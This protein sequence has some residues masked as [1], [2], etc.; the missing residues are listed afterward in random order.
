MLGE[1]E[2]DLTV[3]GKAVVAARARSGARVLMVGPT[4][5]GT[6]SLPHRLARLPEAEGALVFCSGSTAVELA[7]PFGV[8]QGLV[9]PLRAERGLQAPTL[10][11]PLLDA[12]FE[13]AFSGN[14][15]AGPWPTTFADV[16]HQFH[17][18]L[19]TISTE[20]TVVLT[21]DD[22]CY[23]DDASLHALAHLSTRPTSQ[24]LLLAVVRET[25][26]S[27]HNPPVG[28]IASVATHQVRARPLSRRCLFRIVA[29]EL[30]RDCPQEFAQA[31]H[32]MS[33]GRPKDLRALCDGARLRRLGRPDRRTEA[34]RE[35]GVAVRRERLFLVLRREPGA[36]ALAKAAAVLGGKAADE[37]GEPLAG[38][39]RTQFHRARSV[40]T[41]AWPDDTADHT[42]VCVPR[43]AETVLRVMGDGGSCRRHR[44]AAGLL[45]RCGAGPEGVAAPL[46]QVDRPTGAREIQQLRVS[47]AAA[48]HRRAFTLEDQE[49]ADRVLG[50]PDLSAELRL[51]TL[52][53]A[54]PR[55][56]AE[57]RRNM[58]K[59]LARYLEC[60]QTLEPARRP[61]PAANCWLERAVI[62]QHRLGRCA[63]A[64][65]R[66]G[67]SCEPALAWGAP[68]AVYRSLAL[69]GLLT[70]GCPGIVVLR[71]AVDTFEGGVNRIE[72][73]RTLIGLGQWLRS[74][75][76]PAGN[77]TL[78]RG[79][80]LAAEPRTAQS[81]HGADT[82][83]RPDR[84]IA[85]GRSR[86]I[87]GRDELFSVLELDAGGP[88]PDR[89]RFTP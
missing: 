58:P 67:L 9:R 52:H 87:A 37:P 5:S 4:G 62:I 78:Q 12:V 80:R 28:E 85:A 60:G 88:V 53:R 68:T 64:E 89:H 72:L 40:L 25:L 86:G 24:H 14:R 49:L 59:A 11:A 44:E 46:L 26:L 74:A 50:G 76:D 6:A 63:E 16:L 34:S 17:I 13:E 32:E 70:E 3:L 23:A 27:A 22:L 56:R 19:A 31:G 7:F 41:T 18:L 30:G 66:A 51:T 10:T 65:R 84:A 69:R 33:G 47:V 36:S 77:R 42:G 79:R 15:S 21:L 71:D 2:H 48:R 38:L 55:L 20:R 75:A 57:T 29:D 73:A 35:L 8:L 39:S 43:V 82:V 83:V 54:L 45:E 1:R 61:T 81:E